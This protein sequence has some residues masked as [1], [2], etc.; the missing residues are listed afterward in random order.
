M[1]GLCTTGLDNLHG[2]ATE[3]F[4]SLPRVVKK[5]ANACDHIDA[6]NSLTRA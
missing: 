6:L 1:T 4:P 5:N 2:I 3:A